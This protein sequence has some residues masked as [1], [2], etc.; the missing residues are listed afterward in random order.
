[1]KLRQAGLAVNHQGIDRLCAN[2]KL[3][4]RRR[5]RKNI[6]VSGWQPMVRPCTAN[7]TWS[8]DFV[9]DRTADGRIGKCWKIVNC[10]KAGGD[11]P[12]RPFGGHPLIRILDQLRATHGRPLVIRRD[13]GRGVLWERGADPGAGNARHMARDQ[14]GTS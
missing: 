9:F 3:Q 6:P 7:E 2:A 4:L 14:V 1:M 10:A 11:C 12:E 8:M 5:K 13:D